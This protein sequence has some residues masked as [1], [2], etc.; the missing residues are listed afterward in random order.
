MSLT[1]YEAET[2]I[3]FNEEEKTAHVYTHNKTLIKRLNKCC[4]KFPHLFQRESIELNAVNYTIPKR[5]ISVREPKEYT[6]EQREQ[7]KERGKRLQ[8]AQEQTKTNIA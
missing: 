4:E 6:P 2:I 8:Q 7:M 1:A 3:N 5:Y